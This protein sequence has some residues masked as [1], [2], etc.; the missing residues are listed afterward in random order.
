[1]ETSAQT[2][3]IDSAMI[4]IQQEL[5]HAILDKKGTFKNPYA[6]LESVIDA[7]RPISSSKGI[8]FQ[9]FPELE[10]D[11]NVLTTRIAH[12]SGQ[13]YITKMKLIFTKLDMQ[14]LGAAITYSK[15]Y[16]LSSIFGIGSGGEDVDDIHPIEENKEN[17]HATTIAK[18]QEEIKHDQKDFEIINK[19]VKTINEAQKNFIIESF[20]KSNR[21]LDKMLYHFNVKT[22]EEL[23]QEQALT[24]ISSIK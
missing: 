14:S 7:I 15:R 1:M 19:N 24:V 17:V 4:E 16:V 10:G 11:F 22:I 8:S 13:Y 12:K 23:T 20:K 6:S 9:Q 18:R 3:L 2:D 5:K 21:D